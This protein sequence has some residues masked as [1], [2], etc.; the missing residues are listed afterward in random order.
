MWKD[1]DS[2]QVD[3]PMSLHI[4]AMPDDHTIQAVV[5]GPLVLSGKLGNQGLTTEM[6]YPGY[7]TAPR[8]T[9]A[10]MPEIDNRSMNPVA[11]VEAAQGAPLTFRTV[12]QSTGTNVIPF[13][14]VAGEKYAV[15]W[16]VKSPGRPQRES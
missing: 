12:G 16:K 10:E 6:M 15:Y 14:K 2:I 9:P 13:Y 8:A 11:W 4:E 1:G 3:L 7:D 5:Y